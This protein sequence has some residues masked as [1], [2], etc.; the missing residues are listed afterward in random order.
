M[1]GRVRNREVSKEWNEAER[2]LSEAMSE[3][4]KRERMERQIWFESEENKGTTFYFT[5]PIE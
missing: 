5:L 3:V 2:R 1:Q 4:A